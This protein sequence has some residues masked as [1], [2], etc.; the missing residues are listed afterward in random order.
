MT[1]GPSR[2]GGANAGEGR[3]S[4]IRVSHNAAA[5]RFEAIVDGLL[6][7]A[8]YRLDGRTMRVHHTGVPP[9]LEGRGIAAALVRAVFE[10]AAAN[11]LQVDPLCS[12]VRAWTRRHPEVGSLLA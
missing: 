12:Y 7:E 2:R 3:G 1:D 9:P 4:A 8:V 5:S 10:H 6:C 11:G